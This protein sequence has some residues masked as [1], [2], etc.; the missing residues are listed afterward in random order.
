M[1]RVW[2][3]VFDSNGD[4]LD[5][6]Y[7]PVLLESATITH[8]L[9]GSGGIKLAYPASVRGREL[10]MAG[11]SIKVWYETEEGNILLG[12]GIIKKSVSGAADCQDLLEELKYDNTLLNYQIDMLT[13]QAAISGL[14]G[15]LGWTVEASGTALTATASEVFDGETKLKALLLV[16]EHSGTHVRLSPRGGRVM[17]VGNFGERNDITLFDASSGAGGDAWS[18]VF[19]SLTIEEQSEQL[20]NRIL[21]VGGAFSGGANVTLASSTRTGISTI[22]GQDGALNYYIENAA[23]VALYGVRWGY[24]TYPDIKPLAAGAPAETACANQ[25]YDAAAVD[26][27]NLSVIRRNFK[28]KVRGLKTQLLPGDAVRVLYNEP[29]YDDNGD[30]WSGGALDEYLYITRVETYAGEGGWWQNIDLSN[31]NAL[32][33]D[34]ATDVANAVAANKKAT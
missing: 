22:A 2:V 30:L 25:L 10:L 3:D 5:N 17:E 7:G 20:I 26:L 34:E 18:G 32:R 13:V 15:A 6:A 21:P 4:S 9:D 1:S 24:K 31:V 11:R 33:I 27:A 14:I 16:A 23:S 19:E 28:G 29:I 12:E 8:M